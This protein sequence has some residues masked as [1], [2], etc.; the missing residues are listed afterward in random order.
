[1]SD[2]EGPETGGTE[3]RSIGGGW[4]GTY[5][6][7]GA[8]RARPPVRF[9]AT[10]REPDSDGRFTG[11]V[12]DDGGLGEADVSG[13]QS[14]R[15]VRFT[16]TYRRGGQPAVSYAGTLAG[17]GQT[18][19]GTWEIAGLGRGVWDARRLWSGGGPAEAEEQAEARAGERVREVVRLG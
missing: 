14:G 2:Y 8:G 9:E 4:L 16:K 3:G 6:Y 15:G 7:K 5:A 10:F 18:V 12:L 13:G 19:Q 1:M 17:D 11:T